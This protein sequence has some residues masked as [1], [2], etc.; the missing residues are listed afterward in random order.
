MN[1]AYL[2]WQ[3]NSASYGLVNGYNVQRAPDVG[4][5]PGTWTEVKTI[6]KSPYSSD[7]ETF[8]DTNLTAN[9]TYWY[10]VYIYNWLGEG[11][12]STARRITIDPPMAPTELSTYV[13]SSNSIEVLWN[14]HFRMDQ[15]GF[16]LER[17][18][19]N[20]TTWT[21]IAIVLATN[22]YHVSYLDTNPVVNVINSYRVRAFNV[23]GYS[24]YSDVIR[25][26]IS[27]PV[28]SP[29]SALVALP[30]P[31]FTQLTITNDSVLLTWTA[32]GG[33]TNVVEAS[34]QPTDNFVPVSPNIIL[35]GSGSVTNNYLDVGAL[36]NSASRFYRIR[37]VP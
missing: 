2:E 22:K 24:T 14:A 7:Y 28:V 19:D 35:T 16:K 15:D 21:E 17:S 12:P 11:N 37:L 18:T 33:T 4:G 8:V 34:A 31:H 20:Q 9:A 5:V 32:T 6:I 36:T 30:S 25:A 3:F 10:R 13:R 23:V 27:S 1:R 26:I 29:I